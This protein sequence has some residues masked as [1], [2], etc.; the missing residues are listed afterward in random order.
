MADTARRLGRPV[1]V[2]GQGQ[3][4]GVL[5]QVYLRIDVQ[6][7]RRSRWGKDTSLRPDVRIGS[8]RNFEGM[9]AGIRDERTDKGKEESE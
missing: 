2:R 3:R 4:M 8:T 7:K 1:L 6:D 5:H 9:G